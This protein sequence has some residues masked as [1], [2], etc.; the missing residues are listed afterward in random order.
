[1][2]QGGVIII[3]VAGGGT[4]ASAPSLLWPAAEVVAHGRRGE[5]LAE[6]MRDEREREEGEGN[7]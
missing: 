1:M 3:V 6:P 7:E 4:Q 5:A 2:D